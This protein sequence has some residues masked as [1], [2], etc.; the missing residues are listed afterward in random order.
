MKILILVFLF[1]FSILIILIAVY[2]FLFCYF[3][4]FVFCVLV[5]EVL[6]I[7]SYGYI[8]DWWLLGIFMYVIFVGRVSYVCEGG[9]FFIVCLLFLMY[10][11]IR[12]YS[13]VLCIS[14]LFVFFWIIMFLEIMIVKL[15]WYYW[16]FFGINF[17]GFCWRFL[18]INYF[19]F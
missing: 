14:V 6:V 3:E 15:R 1:L 4:D 17:C 9:E 13:L 12:F 8:V 18:R 10:I 19:F 2:V 5:F 16:Y 7:I 11:N